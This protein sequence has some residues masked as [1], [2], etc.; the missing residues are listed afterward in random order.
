MKIVR[1]ESGQAAR[2]WAAALARPGWLDGAA[3]LKEEGGAWVRRGVVRLP[4]G[5]RE[6]VVKC[7]PIERPIE[8]IK[9]LFRQGRGD[10]H[11]RGAAWLE[12]H[13]VR[14]A[15]PIVLAR[16]TIDGRVCELL[17]MEALAGKSVLQHLAD[18]DLTV[19]QEHTVARELGRVIARLATHA[20]CNRDHKPS[21]LI[22][23]RVS[24]TDAEV[25]LVD[26]VAIVHDLYIDAEAQ[27]KML[28]ALVI[29]AIG[30]G[31]EPR[32]S[33]KCRVIQE[34]I[35][36]I[37]DATSPRMRVDRKKLHDSIAELWLD[38]SDR[39]R[40]HGNPTPRV[41]PLARYTAPAQREP[42]P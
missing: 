27:E 14:T 16:A 20:R 41:D 21:N 39:V 23:T 29:E 12:R 9:C 13:G 7:R 11:W 6:V 28:A 8:R 40:R 3:S 26:T 10:R 2:E 5:P 36:H 31:H 24:Y 34:L 32:Q 1:S 19:R 4:D 30:T 33:L 38:V 17:V 42:P 18:G 35:L 22:V 25:A 15:H 37:A